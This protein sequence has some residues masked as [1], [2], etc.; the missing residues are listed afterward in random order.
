M[1]DILDVIKSR[2]SVKKYKSDPVPKEL[3]E[4]IVAAGSGSFLQTFAG[5][6][7]A[8]GHIGA[9][10]GQGNVQRPANLP[11]EGLVSVRGVAPQMVIEVACGNR[12][13]E[14]LCCVGDAVGHGHGI[15]AAG[16]GADH[17]TAGG[18]PAAQGGKHLIPHASTLGRR[19]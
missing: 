8:G 7:A 3:L 5:F 10:Y 9:G 16:K 19:R 15:G 4:K 1:G 18:Y 6:P 11:A 14:L 2:K 13:A 12:Y 17:M